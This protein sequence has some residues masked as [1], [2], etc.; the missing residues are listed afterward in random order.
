MVQ[1][2]FLSSCRQRD[3]SEGRCRPGLILTNKWT[4]SLD[5]VDVEVESDSEV[6]PSTLDARARDKTQLARHLGLGAEKS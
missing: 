5:L 6:L 3:K 2:L 4:F 1:R